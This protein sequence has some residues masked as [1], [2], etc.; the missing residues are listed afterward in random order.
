MARL[1]RIESESLDAVLNEASKYPDWFIVGKVP[2]INDGPPYVMMIREQLDEEVPKKVNVTTT[3]YDPE[4]CACS[5]NS[6]MY[7]TYHDEGCDHLRP[8]F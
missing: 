1:R 5:S 6:R 3:T 2:T 4:G 8:D 7:G